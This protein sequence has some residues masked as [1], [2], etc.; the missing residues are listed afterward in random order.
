MLSMLLFFGANS[1]VWEICSF[2]VTLAKLKAEF[3]DKRILISHNPDLP[4]NSESLVT[5]PESQSF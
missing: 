4:V 1:T 5:R 3:V 2:A